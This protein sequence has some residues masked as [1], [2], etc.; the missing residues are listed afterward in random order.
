MRKSRKPLRNLLRAQLPSET[1][2]TIWTLLR[3]LLTL[4]ED[5]G[6]A[7]FTLFD[8][9]GETEET[10]PYLEELKGVALDAASRY[11]QLANIQLRITEAKPIAPNDMLRLLYQ[12]IN[13]NQLRI[14]AL[15][16]CIQE[17]KIEW[18][19]P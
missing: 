5:A 12:A 10:I 9:F 16:G 1:T 18:N 15:E 17:I 4:V 3:Q 7:E 14:P 2:E 13:Q 19:L 11:A 8:R 6:A